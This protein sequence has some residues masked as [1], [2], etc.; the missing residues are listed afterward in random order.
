MRAGELRRERTELVLLR[1][2]KS[3]AIG[4]FLVDKRRERIYGLADIR[5]AKGPFVAVVVGWVY[6]LFESLGAGDE[7]D[8]TAVS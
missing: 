5:P 3:G 7:L 2:I 4:G 1:R 6:A 8:R